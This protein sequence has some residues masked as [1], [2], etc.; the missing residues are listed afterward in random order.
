MISKPAGL[1]LIYEMLFSE[2][3]RNPTDEWSRKKKHRCIVRWPCEHE[4]LPNCI[5]NIFVRCFRKV[6]TVF[7]RN[8][9]ILN[10][11]LLEIEPQSYM[12]ITKYMKYQ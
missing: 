5:Y 1:I 2:T 8:R 12:I 3:G 6:V 7:G 4:R 9:K 11:A 10:N